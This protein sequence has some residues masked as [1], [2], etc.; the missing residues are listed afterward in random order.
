MLIRSRVRG[1]L[2]PGALLLALV[3]LLAGAASYGCGRAHQKVALPVTCL[4]FAGLAV[5]LGVQPYRTG[6]STGFGLSL[7]FI[8]IYYA[9][10]TAG[11]LLA[12]TLGALLAAWLPGCPT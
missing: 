6:V 10:M 8:L 9:L 1:Y 4:A 5:P 2:S 7:L 3:A 11:M 12:G